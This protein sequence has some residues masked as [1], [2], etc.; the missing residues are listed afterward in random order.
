MKVSVAGGGREVVV[1]ST[2]DIGADDPLA[3]LFAVVDKARALWA[4]TA[5]D[6]RGDGP[7]IGFVAEQTTGADLAGV[8]HFAIKPLHVET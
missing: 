6:D 2:I 7:A 1:E 4:S 5:T 8:A 3:V